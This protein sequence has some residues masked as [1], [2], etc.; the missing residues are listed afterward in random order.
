ML[1]ENIIL[2][3]KRKNEDFRHPFSLLLEASHSSYPL[4]T[5]SGKI[6]L[7]CLSLLVNST[8][9][10]NRDHIIDRSLLRQKIIQ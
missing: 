6:T 4:V 7:H 1:K 9:R 5:P 8:Q 10:S 3:S 2:G